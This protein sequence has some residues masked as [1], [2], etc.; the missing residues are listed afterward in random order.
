MTL[1]E[2][3]AREEG[4]TFDRKSINV[5]AKGLAVAITAMANADGG[6][7]VVGL[8]DKSRRVE[9]VDQATEHVND[10]LRVPFDYCV[11]SVEARIEYVPCTDANGHGNRL[12]VF[13]IS[14]SEKVHA[15][16]ADEVFLRVGDKN[17]KLSFEERFTLMSDKGLIHFETTAVQGS[18]M[19][20]I[21]M[22]LVEDYI[23]RLHYGKS[24]REFLMENR[25]YLVRKGEN[26]YPSAVSILLFGK[27]PQG[28]FPR[29]Q[30]RFIR[31]EGTEEK[32]GR[33]MNVI[34]D[35]TF[36][37]TLRQ[38][39]EDA[40]AYLST[41]V[42]EHT[43]L[44]PKGLFVTEVEYP[45]FVRQEIIVNAVCHR[46]YNIYGTDIQVKMFDDRL[47]VESPGKLPGMVRPENIRHTHFSRNPLIAQYLKTYTYVREFGEG[48][49][50][51][52]RE[53][54]AQGLLPVKYC[55]QDFMTQATAYNQSEQKRESAEIE[56]K[57]M[58]EPPVGGF[59]DFESAT[60]LPGEGQSVSK[61]RGSQS[62][63]IVEKPAIQE[64]NSGYSYTINTSGETESTDSTTTEVLRLPISQMIDTDSIKQQLALKK[65]KRPTI[66]K[67]MKLC[68]TIKVNEVFGS[69]LVSQILFCSETQARTIINILKE[70]DLIV[71]VTKQGKGKYI[72][73]VNK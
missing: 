14:A 55:Q 1:Q 45:E 33:E 72:F 36:G 8:S 66:I 70:L 38:Q 67:I 22:T 40:V 47:V 62:A 28:F 27:K 21:D 32:V 61:I 34:K 60:F 16:Q 13:H 71:P 26:I 73:A 9:G 35:V 11:P 46:D 57:P 58:I 23:S 6:D 12:L 43:F 69:R 39:I 18:G 25:G 54:E 31:Y 24:A 59:R 10:L 17:K 44:G 68:D 41:Q 49:D 20:D 30:V 29:A 19:D 53:M 64:Q 63:E 4:Q 3:I 7:I 37:G 50:R 15:N 5:D 56:Q 2:I 65:S 42:K 51:M 52:C 48:V